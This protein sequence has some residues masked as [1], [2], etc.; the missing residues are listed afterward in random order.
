MNKMM[1][2]SLL[3]YCKVSWPTA[4][5]QRFL[6]LGRGFYTFDVKHVSKMIYKNELK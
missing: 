6:H 5:M 1:H 4:T 3:I 2:Y